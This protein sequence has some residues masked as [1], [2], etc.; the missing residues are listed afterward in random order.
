MRTARESETVKSVVLRIDSPG[1]DAAA[2]EAMWHEVMLTRRKKPVIVSMG[3]YAASGG[4]YIAAGADSIVAEP[5]TLT[6]SIGVFALRFNTA[7]LMREKLGI[8]MQ[9]ITSNPHADMMSSF[10]SPDELERRVLS[11]RTD[12]IYAEFTRVVA[13]GRGLALDRVDSLAQGRV[14]TGREA[15]ANGLVDL[16]GGIDD[17]VRIAAERGGLKKGS[18][19]IRILPRRQT[20][21]EKVGEMF[22][23]AATAFSGTLESRF[24]DSLIERLEQMSGIQAL[25]PTVRID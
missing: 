15:K 8:N 25:M 3:G 22:S 19:S 2:S 23:S 7:G 24:Y 13:D 10:R 4:Y 16:L 9:S 20:F 6:G 12:S 5:A 21:I 17:A 11:A 14:W 18:Y 1:G